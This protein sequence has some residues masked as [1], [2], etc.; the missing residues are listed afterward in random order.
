[1]GI[2]V[3]Y[4]GGERVT[5]DSD[6]DLPIIELSNGFEYYLANDRETAGIQAREL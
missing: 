2:I 1:M 3:A 4:I 5:F 6:S